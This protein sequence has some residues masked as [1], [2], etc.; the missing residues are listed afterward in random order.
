MANEILLDAETRT[1]FGK[2]AARRVR[3]ANK[4]PAVMYGHGSDPV[5][6][7][8]PGHATM[9]A[10]RN[11]NALLTLNLEGGEKQL[12][13]P[14]QIQRHPVTYEIEHVDLIM[15]KR[16]ERV[17]VEIPVIV[18]DEEKLEDTTLV[19][20]LERGELTVS[21][22]ATNIPRD[23]EISVAG[24]N[25]DNQVVAG[26]IELPEGVELEEDPETLVVSISVPDAVPETPTAEDEEGAEEESSEAAEE[27][28]SDE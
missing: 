2:G 14:R 5:H 3:R 18:V 19:V 13:L 24:F 1:E 7:A 23:V 6:I 10:L 22:E 15:V 27:E 20:N 4:V 12:A 21:A 11:S 8:L 17:T 9:L 26:D 28:S 25:L 16:G